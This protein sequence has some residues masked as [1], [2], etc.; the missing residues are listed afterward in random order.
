[1]T[2]K[3]GSEYDSGMKPGGSPLIGQ[4]VSGMEVARVRSAAFE[5]NRRRRF[6][7]T[8][9]FGERQGRTVTVSEYPSPGTLADRPVVVVKAL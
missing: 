5:W 8:A 2:S 1:M 3:P 4:V 9:R 6:P 7:D